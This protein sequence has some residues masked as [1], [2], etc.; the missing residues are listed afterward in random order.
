M[1][2]QCYGRIGAIDGNGRQWRAMAM[3]MATTP[4][5]AGREEKNE[6][7]LAVWHRVVCGVRVGA[8]M[9]ESMAGMAGG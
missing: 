3:A 6:R 9:I 1:L 7:I 4:G 5:G 2:E 8:D